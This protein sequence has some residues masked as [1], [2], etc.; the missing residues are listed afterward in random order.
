MNILPE[1]FQPATAQPNEVGTHYATHING[2]VQIEFKGRII[3]TYAIRRDDGDIC[4]LGFTGRYRTGT[5]AWR[6][7]VLYSG[8][9]TTCEFGFESRSWKH[10]KSDISFSP[11]HFYGTEVTA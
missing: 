9:R 7:R 4:A 11:A 6:C 1:T 10:R 8:D 3:T 5:K 2:T